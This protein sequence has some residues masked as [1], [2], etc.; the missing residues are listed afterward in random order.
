MVILSFKF[1]FCLCLHF[2]KLLKPSE[3]GSLLN[4]VPS[5]HNGPARVSVFLISKVEKFLLHT[6]EAALVRTHVASDTHGALNCAVVC[7]PSSGLLLI[8]RRTFC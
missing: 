3:V 5:Q 1:D 7:V 8:L 2:P 6:S 4:L